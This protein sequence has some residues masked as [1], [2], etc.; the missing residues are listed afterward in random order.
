MFIYVFKLYILHRSL[1]TSLQVK[2]NLCIVGR[3]MDKVKGEE[4][5]KKKKKK[6]LQKIRK[7]KQ[8]NTTGYQNLRVRK[9]K[10]VSNNINNTSITETRVKQTK[11]FQLSTSVCRPSFVGSRMPPL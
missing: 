1:L 3:D 2:F 8:S 11:P 9:Q 10:A 5:E 4:N 7:T 6:Q